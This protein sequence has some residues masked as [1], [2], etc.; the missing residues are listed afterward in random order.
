MKR[1]SQNDAC[2]YNDRETDWNEKEWVRQTSFLIKIGICV[3]V[4]VPHDGAGWTWCGPLYEIIK[5]FSMHI[6]S[7]VFANFVKLVCVC[8]CRYVMWQSRQWNSMVLI[9]LRLRFSL[10]NFQYF[11]LLAKVLLLFCLH[12]SLCCYSW[13]LVS[14]I[15]F[16]T[17]HDSTR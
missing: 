16:P 13:C 2:T 8:V 7:I 9:L 1:I 15:Q 4:C 12:G 3:C 5:S 14:C 6:F 10:L 11:L 17:Q